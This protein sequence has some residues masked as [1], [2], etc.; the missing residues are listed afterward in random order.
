MTQA[1]IIDEIEDIMQSTDLRFGQIIFQATSR[2]FFFITDDAMLVMLRALNLR[3]QRQ[4]RWHYR[5][6]RR[7]K[8]WFNRLRYRPTKWRTQ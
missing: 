3:L 6:G 4:N 2:P 7:L 5:L 8:M 1:L